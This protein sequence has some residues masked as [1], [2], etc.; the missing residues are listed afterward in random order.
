MIDCNE[1]YADKISS[2]LIIIQFYFY[3]NLDGI[4]TYSTYTSKSCINYTKVK[5][6]HLPFHEKTV[7]QYDGRRQNFNPISYLT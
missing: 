3:V 4:N 7:S 6:Y 2:T 5:N 1:M